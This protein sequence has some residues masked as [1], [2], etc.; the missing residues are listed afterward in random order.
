M[1]TSFFQKQQ[2]TLIL[3]GLDLYLQFRI[4]QD[5]QKN[6]IVKYLEA[7]RIQT[8]M[9]F[10]G[11]LTKQPAFQG[12]NYRIYGDLTNTDKILNDTFLV[13]VYPGLTNE[14]IDYV[15]SKIKEFVLA[16]VSHKQG[17]AVK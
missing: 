4:M 10:A 8:R 5:L 13:G 2:K 12:V 6:E 9:L 14:M 1:N 11:N 15:I 17:E 3:V 16:K 7:N